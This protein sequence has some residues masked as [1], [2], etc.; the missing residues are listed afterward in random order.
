MRGSQTPGFTSVWISAD[1]PTE[2]AEAMQYADLVTDQP[3]TPVDADGEI[4][5]HRPA[6]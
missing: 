3:I 4:T 2:I 1:L 6:G 5:I